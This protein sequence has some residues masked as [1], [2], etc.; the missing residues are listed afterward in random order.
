MAKMMKKVT[1][2]GKLT[3][4]VTSAGVRK[5]RAEEVPRKKQ[6]GVLSGR[7]ISTSLKGE[8]CHGLLPVKNQKGD[9]CDMVPY[10]T[11]CRKQGDP[12]LRV[13]DHP[14]FGK[15]LVAKRDLPKGYRMAWWGNRTTARKLP[16]PHW[17][18]A[19]DTQ[20]GIINARPYQKGSLLQFSACPG[21]HEKVTVWMG[22]RCDSNLDKSP[23]TCLVFSTTMPV[24]KN[25]HLSMMYNDSPKS[26]DEFFAE[27]GI[28]RADVGTKKYP[29][30][31]K[32]QFA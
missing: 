17:E 27:R 5:R 11:T 20:N 32:A 23:L 1:R 3:R 26:T 9:L 18:W 2:A 13:T 7:C 15:I 8:P 10:C 19:L 16:E 28:K 4:K 14:K 22:P 12:S 6:H 29:A 31:R 25:H 30:I 21:P 24:P